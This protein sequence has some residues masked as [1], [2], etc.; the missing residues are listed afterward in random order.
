MTMSCVMSHGDANHVFESS[1]SIPRHGFPLLEGKARMRIYTNPSTLS[2][3]GYDFPRLSRGILVRDRETKGPDGGE[4]R[5]PD[6]HPRNNVGIPLA[7]DEGILEY[8]A[9][10][11]LDDGDG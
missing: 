10:N 9:G 8:E 1:R 2:S 4:R 6:G 11:A 7:G 3:S 5:A